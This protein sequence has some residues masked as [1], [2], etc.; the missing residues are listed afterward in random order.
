MTALSRT[1]LYIGDLFK[2][3]PLSFSEIL[4]AWEEDVMKPFELVRGHVEEELGEVSGARLYGAYLNPETMTAVIE[5]MV[6]FEGEK[7]M[8]VYSVK[9]VHAE[10]PQKAMMEYHKAER[11]GKLVR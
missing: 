3:L 8:G 11:E 2:P 1:Y 6:D 4:E 5:Y 9:I 10:N 7:V